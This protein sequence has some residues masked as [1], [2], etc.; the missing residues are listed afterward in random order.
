MPRSVAPEVP[1]HV[2]V[3]RAYVARD[4]SVV[5]EIVAQG[6]HDGG[7]VQPEAG[8]ACCSCLFIDGGESVALFAGGTVRLGVE[9]QAGQQRRELAQGPRDIAMQF[10]GRLVMVVY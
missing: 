2:D 6:E 1:G 10:D 7:R 5:G 3:V 8:F 9:P 4:G